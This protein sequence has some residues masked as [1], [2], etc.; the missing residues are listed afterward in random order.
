MSENQNEQNK[1]NKKSEKLNKIIK[2]DNKQSDSHNIKK[3]S[4]GPNTKR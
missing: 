2:K 3:E 4:L 1:Q